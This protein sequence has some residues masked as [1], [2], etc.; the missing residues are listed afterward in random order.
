MSVQFGRCNF[1]GEP[2]NPDYLSKVMTT[3]L[4]HGTDGANTYRDGHVGVLYGAFH[5]TKESRREIQPYLSD[6]GSVIAWDGR[7]DNREELA[8]ELESPK[9]GA[10]TDLTLVAAAYERWGIDSF[11]KLKGDWA[12]SVVNLAESSVVLAK[13][14]VGTRHLYYMVE[15]RGVT[16]STLL[17]PLVLFADRCFAL[18]E[19]YIA[20]WLSFFP[21][22]HLTPYTSIHSVPPSSCV[23]IR[24]GRSVSKQYRT[25]DPNKKIRYHTDAEYEEHFRTLFKESVRHRLRSDKPTIA[26]LSGGM[27]SSSIVCVADD[28][29]AA[30]KAETARLDTVSYYN[31][32]EPNW[33]ERRYFQKVEQ[34]RGRSGCHIDLSSQEMFDINVGPDSFLATPATRLYRSQADKQSAA[35]MLSQENRV[36]LSGIGG[37][38]VLGGVPTPLPELADLLAEIQ[39]RSLAHQLKVWALQSR[40]PWMRLFL[41]TVREFLPRSL[42]RTPRDRQPAP[43]LRTTFVNRYRDTFLNYESRV[44]LFGSPPSFQ[45]AVKTLEGV[46]RQIECFSVPLEL[47]YEKRYPFLD[48]DLLEFL[49]AVPREQ[50]VRPGQRRSLMRRALRGIVPDEILN[51]RRKASASRAPLVAISAEWASLVRVTERMMGEDLGI[52]DGKSFSEAL[53]KARYGGDVPIGALIR[54]LDLEFWLRNLQECNLSTRVVADVHPHIADGVCPVLPDRVA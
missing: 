6:W 38:E 47:P 4:P 29:I 8:L 30:G 53:R 9:A 27:D 42:T 54:T 14:I 18:N 23:L 44:K 31:D 21:A 26:E 2:V 22:T 5:T 15:S 24:D 41:D 19:E 52:V 36:V 17:E 50:L 16:W 25:F 13:D 43:W 37:D 11:S 45:E 35:Y 7:L 32:S 39:F 12:L 3:L 28:L 49:Y 51:R 1:D 20:G 40:K 46:Q 34:R 33:D 48:R 10:A